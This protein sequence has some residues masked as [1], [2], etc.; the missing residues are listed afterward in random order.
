M[1]VLFG[2]VF[3][4]L[5][6]K[7]GCVELEIEWAKTC[8]AKSKTNIKTSEWY[9]LIYVHVMCMCLVFGMNILGWEECL[10]HNSKHCSRQVAWLMIVTKFCVC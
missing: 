8:V 9:R 1:F 7:D 3:N 6:R 2:M 4:P 10:S 5:S